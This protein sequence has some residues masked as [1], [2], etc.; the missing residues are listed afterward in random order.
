ME[1]SATPQTA[2]E[3]SLCV[4]SS[5][6]NLSP[7]HGKPVP[8]S[9]ATPSEP[10][11]QIN[12]RDL[13]VNSPCTSIRGLVGPDHGCR[14]PNLRDQIRHASHNPELLS[15]TVGRTFVAMRGDAVS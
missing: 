12:A 8:A 5:A 14:E 3:R 7:D 6:P 10:R 4:P 9:I 1:P 15:W 2:D 13:V 11:G